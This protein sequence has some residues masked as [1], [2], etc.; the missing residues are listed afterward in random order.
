MDCH[1][2][3]NGAFWFCEPSGVRRDRKLKP[4]DEP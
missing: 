2:V 3:A 4:K 1:T